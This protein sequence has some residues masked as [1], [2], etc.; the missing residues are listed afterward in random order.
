MTIYCVWL[1]DGRCLFCADETTFHEPQRTELAD[2]PRKGVKAW[3]RARIE[4]L[5]TRFHEDRTGALAWIRSV[6]N[7]LQSWTRPDEPMLVRLWRAQALRL[8]HPANLSGEQVR[9]LW[10][11]YL[12]AQFRRHLIWMVINGLLAPPSVILAILPGPNLIGYW[13]A[14]RAVH[15]GLAVWGIV[16]ARRQRIPI[17]LEPVPGLNDPVRRGQDGTIRHVELDAAAARIEEH[18]AR[19]HRLGG[20]RPV[21]SRPVAGLV[22]A[23]APCSIKKEDNADPKL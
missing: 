16:R 15:H 6:W 11:D 3:I 9:A 21:G 7:W 18:L 8:R 17:E 10:L 23:S 22:G 5:I 12:K 1:D 19:S 13:F 20:P 4:R 2:G 14:Y